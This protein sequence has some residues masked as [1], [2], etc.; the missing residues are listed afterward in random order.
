MEAGGLATDGRG[1]LW[2]I[3]DGDK[4][5]KTYSVSDG[6][7]LGSLKKDLEEFGSPDK[8][9]LLEGMS[10]L[11]CACRRNGEWKVKVLDVQFENN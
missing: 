3:D 6:K 8:I 1:H 4:S 7:Y 11:L 10:S 9:C 2:V 5:I